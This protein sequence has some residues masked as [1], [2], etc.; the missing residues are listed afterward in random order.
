M[1]KIG[2]IGAGNIGVFL[3][4]HLQAQGHSVV[5][6]GRERLK[7][8]INTHGITITSFQKKQAIRLESSKIAYGTEPE[9]LK[10]CDVFFVTVKSGDTTNVLTSLV[11]I[12]GDAQEKIF[13]SF[14]NG[15]SNAD[16]ISKIFPKTNVFPGMVPYNISYQ[17]R[18]VFHLGTSGDLY[19]QKS[20]ETTEIVN[21]LN[22]AGL[23][24]KT[25]ANMKGVLYGKLIFNLNN[26][27]NALAGIPLK[28][29]LSDSLFRK[30]IASC[31]RE[32]LGI[33]KKVRITPVSLGTLIP[34]IAPAILSLPNILFFRIAS[35]MVQIDPLAR[36]SM[37]EDL[38]QKRK[39]EF[40]F[41]NGEIINLAHSH[42]LSAP[43]QEKLEKLIR[44]AEE[45]KNGSPNWS[46]RELKEKL[47]I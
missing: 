28:E 7:K 42:S 38:E 47:G 21:A 22:S 23:S 37:W 4:A 26:A 17:Q 9:L 41:I 5:F 33:Y 45:K 44:E 10:S 8:E 3:G 43:I 29:E 40:A 16:R 19:V 35:K 18:G 15:V 20:S 25:H 6:Y 2:I 14:Q 32:A 27:I 31:M 11:P 1:L 34:K 12:L 46:S 30:I 36:S 13:V 24:C 39:T